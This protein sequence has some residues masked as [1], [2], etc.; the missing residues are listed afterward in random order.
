MLISRRV[1]TQNCSPRRQ[2]LAPIAIVLHATEGNAQSVFFHF[3][4]PKAQVSSHY[5]I[6]RNGEIHQFVSNDMSAWHA[7]NVSKPTARMVIERDAHR[8]AKEYNVNDWTL[9]IEV[10]WERGQTF[11][12]AQYLTLYELVDH[13]TKAFDIAVDRIHIFGHREVYALKYCPATLDIERIIK[14]VLN[15]RS[16]GVQVAPVASS[17]IEELS[18]I[19]QQILRIRETLS[20]FLESRGKLGSLTSEK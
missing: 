14:G 9:G 15:L 6:L 12:D 10:E 11:T 19:Q 8:I 4:N 17:P 5:L 2:G 18:K 7:G 16:P 20:R 13:L 3:M 1:Y